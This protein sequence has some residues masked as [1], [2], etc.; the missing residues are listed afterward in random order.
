MKSKLALRILPAFGL[1]TATLFA[2]EA[3]TEKKA[4]ETA[5][6]MKL[7]NPVSNLISVPVQNNFDFG[8]GPSGDGFQYKIDV[9][10]VIPFGISEDWN[11][12]SRTILPYIYQD[13]VIGTSSQSGLSDTIQS[14]FF[15]PKEPT[16]DGWI[17]GAGPVFL[18]PTATNDLLGTEKWGTGPTAVVL[19]QDGGWTYGAL[20][21]HIWSFAGDGNRQDVNA[22][23]IQPFVSY[24]TDQQTTYDISTET[25]YDW[26]NN[27]F[28]VP[29][30]LAV[31]Q[32]VNIGETPVQ[33]TLAGKYYAEAPDQGPEWGLRFQVTLLFPKS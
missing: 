24:T 2:Q 20:A 4:A 8:A 29:L 1:L 28:T 15:S 10:P 25:G 27:Q 33:F 7:S 13:D 31:S 26:A 3:V 22:S 6:A 30:I 14:F 19:K 16:D 12:I 21:N 18:V 17:W 23:F 32:L 11:L 9:R 5:L